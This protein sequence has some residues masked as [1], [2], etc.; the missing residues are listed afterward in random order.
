MSSKKRIEYFVQSSSACLFMQL[1]TGN[2]FVLALGCCFPYNRFHQGSTRELSRFK[3]RYWTIKLNETWNFNS[4]KLIWK[5]KYYF[6]ALKTVEFIVE[7]ISCLV[8]KFVKYG[9]P[10]LFSVQFNWMNEI[11]RFLIYFSGIRMM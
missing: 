2:V 6:W 11:I 7:N 4:L 5:K 9:F 1:Q 3:Y 10:S 8:W